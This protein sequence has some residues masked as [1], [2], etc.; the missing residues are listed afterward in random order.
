MKKMLIC[1]G[2]LCMTLLLFCGTAFAAVEV[3]KG[4]DASVTVTKDAAEKV[5]TVKKSDAKDGQLYLVMIQKGDASA[6]PTADNLYYLNVDK[7]SGTTFSMDAYPK[8]LDEGTYVVYLS[9]Y[10][11]SNNGARK[12]VATLSVTG[13]GGGGGEAT[14]LYG[15]VNGDGKVNMKDLTALACFCAD[16]KAYMPGGEKAI[17]MDN[18]NCNGKGNVDLRD[19]RSLAC[20]LADQ[21]E[22]AVLPH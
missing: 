13:S 21:K 11:G 16:Q 15:D 1:C 17:N 3:Q 12:Q 7:V 22:Y 8:D 10:S 6:K 19:L 5:F 18:A 2:V 4:D 9:D 14:I 20:H